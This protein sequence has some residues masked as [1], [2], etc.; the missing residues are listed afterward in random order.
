AGGTPR[1]L[2][3]CLPEP[4]PASWPDIGVARRRLS[5]RQRQPAAM[6]P[7]RRAVPDRKRRVRDRPLR[8]PGTAENHLP[9]RCRRY[10]DL[11]LG[12]TA[13]LPHTEAK[14]KAPTGLEGL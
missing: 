3:L 11:A 6:R 12:F 2:R 9:R 13:E 10:L 1:R 5:R 14:G 4:L 8:R 7:S